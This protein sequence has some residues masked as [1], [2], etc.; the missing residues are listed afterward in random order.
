VT[1]QSRFD[2]DDFA[3]IS[4]RTLLRGL[5]G[6]ALV[7]A[8]G[9]LFTRPLWAQ[10]TFKANPFSLG[11]A[12]G[13]PAPNGF[14][15]WTR[16]APDPLAEGSGMP[17]RPVEVT[18]QVAADE[19]MAKVVR[20]GTATAHP[21]L[22]H[23]VHVE[24]EGL[25]PARD[26]FYRFAVGGER[27]GIGRAKT[28][29]APGSTVEQLRFALANC[30]KYEDGH[31]IAYRHIAGERFDFVLFAG[32]YIY[33]RRAVRPG[34]RKLPVVRV[35]PG[36]PEETFTLDNYRNRYAIYKL[37]PD[38]QAA[39]ASTAFIMSYDDHE[40]ANNWAGDIPEKP[41]PRE[42]FLLRR[43]A[44]FQA[45]YENMPVR[46]AQMPRGPDILAYR[47]F[48]IGDLVSMHVLDTRLFRTHQPCGGGVRTNCAEALESNRTMLGA[49][50]E[51][52]LYEG[53]RSARARWNVLG[54]Q[55]IMMRNDRDPDPGV[56]AP[57]M[58]K[59]DG[60]VAARDRLFDAVQDTRLSNLVVLSGDIHQ[61]WAG[62]LKRDFN[63]MKSK[64]LGVEF[65]GTSISSDGDGF[66]ISKRYKALLAQSPHIRFFNNQ[67][68]YV[69]HV[70]T[71][72]RWQADYQVLDKISEP[73]AR[74]STRRSFVV[75]DGKPGLSDT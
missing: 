64:T 13:D 29:P 32:D 33:E 38:L 72:K 63:E 5:A 24:I 57:H 27:S 60:A 41:V 39:H 1:Q 68:G 53:F 59:W 10:P 3:T 52:W 22:G 71:T 56:F 6:S 55:V 48:M 65:V 28:L 45:W 62:E 23:S 4:R 54:Q 67:R 74:M 8:T 47:R 26:Y 14:V 12:A 15:L 16:I 75:E 49:T 18:W 7:T 69:R 36:G 66:D 46:R 25:D 20:Q 21:E 35:M 19:G 43:A 44:A 42:R 34:E 40:V 37:D 30:Q 50:Q 70:V 11:L 58:D 31:F 51:R 61:N 2:V 17:D 9:G 73:N